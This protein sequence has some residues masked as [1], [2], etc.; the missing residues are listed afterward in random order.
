MPDKTE[1]S[2]NLRQ[3]I[4]ALRAELTERRAGNTGASSHAS[5]ASLLSSLEQPLLDSVFAVRN[6]AVVMRES[7]SPDQLLQIANSTERAHQRL[8]SLLRPLLEIARIEE[9]TNEVKS[10]V[11]S[12]HSIAHEASLYAQWYYS[13]RKELSFEVDLR[14]DD[15]LIECDAIHL[16]DLI[17]HTAIFV[18]ATLQT[19]RIRISLDASGDRS[20]SEVEWNV[21]IFDFVQYPQFDQTVSL[22]SADYESSPEGQ[23]LIS[24]I[25]ALADELGAVISLQDVPPGLRVFHESA[26]KHSVEPVA[27]NVMQGPWTSV[28]IVTLDAP[29]HDFRAI[30]AEVIEIGAVGEPDDVI[31]RTGAGLVVL[32]HHRD[33]DER[34]LAR[35]ISYAL[36]S[37]VPVLVRASNLSYEDFL[38][39]QS[40]V[41]AIVLEP[42]DKQTLARYVRGLTRTNRRTEKRNAQIH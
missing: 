36:Q 29:P 22:S 18:A 40:N 35:N 3:R 10:D 4:A 20:R 21:S 24:F 32:H 19:G 7:L 34:S 31:R 6:N 33:L 9:R 27:E 14:S 28:P 30:E 12:I 39:Y 41:D 1:I 13:N 38:R 17:A 8:L 23:L 25:G 11:H 2:E 15:K 5:V 16:R 37:S 42:S 26:V